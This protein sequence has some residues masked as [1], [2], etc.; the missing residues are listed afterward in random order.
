MNI[1]Q[2]SDLKYQWDI[3]THLSAARLYPNVEQRRPGCSRHS[4]MTYEVL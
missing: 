1:C 2:L 4:G 3:F